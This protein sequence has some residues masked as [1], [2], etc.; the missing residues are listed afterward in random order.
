L[1]TLLLSPGG[2]PRASSRTFCCY[3]ALTTAALL[4][5]TSAAQHTQVEKNG[6]G[7]IE[8]DY[9]AENNI[10]EMRTIDGDGKLQQKVAY[11]YLAGY[12]AAQQTDTTYWPNGQLRRVVHKSYDASTNYTGELLQLFDDTGRQVA[13]NKLTRDPFTGIY[14]CAEWNVSRRDYRNKECPSGED[15]SGGPEPSKKFSYKEVETNL[16]AARQAA[17]VE[18]GRSVVQEQLALI[19]PS[20]LHRGERISGSVAANPERYLENPELSVTVMTVPETFGPSHLSDWIVEVSGEKLQAA[21]NPI[22]FVV[23]ASGYLQ[24][25]LRQ[26]D[27]PDHSVSATINLSAARETD[28]PKPYRAPALCFKMGVCTV[29]GPFGGNSSTTLAAFEKQ[30]AKIIAE[31][32]TR[33]YIEVPASIETGSYPLCIAEGAKLVALPVTIA[34]FS[35]AIQH[36]DLKAGEHTILFPT[37]IGPETL[38]ETAWRTG[39]FPETNLALAHHLV[40]GFE[41][42]ERHNR[43]SESKEHKSETDTDQDGEILLVIQNLAPGQTSMRASTNQQ[44]VFHLSAESFDHGEFKYNLAVEAAKPGTVQLKAY[45]IPFLAPVIGQVFTVSSATQ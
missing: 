13:G 43:K 6:A 24:I 11:K 30:P 3:F 15:E 38:P 21:D 26:R 23:P 7:R 42:K 19:L 20:R 35:I 2:N 31:T 17:G 1:R 10:V 37:L 39:T 45:A 14:R 25:T 36:A 5:S 33:A 18:S 40:P 22:T 41:L 29:S 28:S 44:M 9:N 32:T 4:V 27:N 12:Y 16:E 34:D 8:T